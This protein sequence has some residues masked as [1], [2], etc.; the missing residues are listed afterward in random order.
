MLLYFFGHCVLDRLLFTYLLWGLYRV[1]PISPCEQGGSCV[2]TPGSFRCDCQVGFVGER[3][4]I[5]V[6]EC[7]SSPCLNDGT[8]LDD[9]GLF[10]C[11][12]IAGKSL[13]LFVSFSFCRTM[14]CINSACAVVMCPAG[15]VPG[16]LSRSCIVSKRL[17]KR[18]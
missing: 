8:C 13:S 17:K 14:L 11:A 18:P 5:N 6:D 10:R 2:N 3:C 4:E 12:C 16:W 15:C 7:A 9:I 1:G